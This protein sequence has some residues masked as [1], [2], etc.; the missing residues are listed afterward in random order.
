MGWLLAKESLW[1]PPLMKHVQLWMT[2]WL[3]KPLAL[4]VRHLFDHKYIIPGQQSLFAVLW[5]ANQAVIGQTL[6]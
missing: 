6:M 5:D 3:T 2:C 4:L 1:P